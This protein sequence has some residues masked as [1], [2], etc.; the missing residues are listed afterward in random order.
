MPRAHF[1]T[2]KMG[3]PEDSEV[4]QDLLAYGHELGMHPAETARVILVE[5]SQARRGH[6]SLGSSIPKFVS[7]VSRASVQERA[8]V[9]RGT[10]PEKDDARE[11]ANA[12][13]ARFAGALN[14]DDD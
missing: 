14:L 11:R 10:G 3:L 8:E 2:W 12:R 7:S 1:K 5:W 6:M 4:W 13:V 9:S